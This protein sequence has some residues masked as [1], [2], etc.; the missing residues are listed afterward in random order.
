MAGE[1][2]EGWLGCRVPEY[3]RRKPD[4]PAILAADETVSWGDFARRVLGAAA[5]FH[6]QGVVPGT[7][8]AILLRDRPQ[9]LVALFALQRLGAATL[10]LDP[11]EPPALSAAL[12]ERA[13]ARF[14]VADR[15]DPV[16]PG[17]AAVAMADTRPQD[18]PPLPPPPGLDMVSFVSR[19]SGTTGGIP[20][21]STATFRLALLRGRGLLERFRRGED[22]RY[23]KLVRIAFSFGRN[24][25]TRALENGGTILLPPPFRDA[26]GLTAYAA[27]TGAT[28]TALT[29]VHLRDLAAADAP[30]PI[31]PGV[32]IL[33][34]TAALS[35]TEIRRIRERV[36]AGLHVGYGTNEVGGLTLALPGDLDERPESVGRVLAGVTVEVVDADGAPLPAGRVGELRFRRPEFPTGYVDP[37]PGS[38]SRFAGGWYYPG[39]VG[40]L[41]ADGY[42]FLKGRLDDVINVGGRKLYPA[43]IEAQL[44]RHPAVAEAAAV[45]VATAREGMIAVAVAVLRRPC[46]PEELLRHCRAG[47]GPAHSPH[48]VVVA[49]AL[50]RTP[51]GKIDRVAIAGAI[52]LE[53]PRPAGRGRRPAGQATP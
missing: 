24:A 22:D 39:D 42:V 18:D 4:A 26:G 48:A 14:L 46:P 12:A 29:P 47:L 20:K 6:A 21:L 45:G 11:D 30:A 36:S 49:D 43:D 50:P 10:C 44:A 40:M 51:L 7:T 17:L 5:D 32:R 13:G 2:E 52:K 35:P 25:A 37:A 9:D 41:D 1:T 19:S 33:C 23:L 53:P 16:P 38:S 28:W 3:A 31:L 27:R 34:S 15:D 8:A